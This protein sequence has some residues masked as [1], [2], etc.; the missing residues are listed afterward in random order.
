MAIGPARGVGR[1]RWLEL[2]KL[3]ES[4][5]NTLIAN[6]YVASASFGNA[7]S[8]ERFELLFNFLSGP[9]PKKTIRKGIAPRSWAIGNKSLTAS[10]KNTGKAF[11]LALKAKDAGDFGEYITERLDDLYEAFQQSQKA[12]TG[13]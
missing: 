5:K 9:K 1:D 10:V 8:D 4:P 2:R 7:D 12:S 3:V 11:S 13:D 6:S